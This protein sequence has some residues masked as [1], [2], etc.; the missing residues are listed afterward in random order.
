[1]KLPKV[2][3]TALTVGGHGPS[4]HRIS[5]GVLRS[6]SGRTRTAQR[7]SNSRKDTSWAML[8]VVTQSLSALQ[9]PAQVT[10]LCNDQTALAGM[11]Q[12]AHRSELAGEHAAD[13]AAYAAAAGPHEIK[14]RFARGEA[15]G[16]LGKVAYREAVRRQKAAPAILQ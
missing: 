15:M 9:R 12:A 5:V 6:A 13:Y 1:M 3:I 11:K 10:V 2:S 14:Y 7:A 16:E 8:W 4:D